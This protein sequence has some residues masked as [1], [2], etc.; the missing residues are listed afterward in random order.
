[1]LSLTM[2]SLCF[3]FLAASPQNVGVS[4]V[5]VEI[6]GYT[7][8]VKNDEIGVQNANLRSDGLFLRSGIEKHA[9][10]RWEEA[11]EIESWAFSFVFNNPHLRSNEQAGIYLR[12]TKEPSLIGPF[13]GGGATYDGIM[14][15]IGFQGMSPRIAYAAN[16]GSDY[17]ILPEYHKYAINYDEIN[18]KRFKDVEEFTFKVIKTK[19]H[20][21][22]EIYDGERLLYDN[23][24][25]YTLGG[26]KGFIGKGGYFAILTD[27]SDAP[28]SKAFEIKRAQLYK[29]TESAE[30]V[31]TD[32]HSATVVRTSR[33]P[34][35]IQHYNSDIATL[36]YRA[37]LAMHTVKDL[38]GDLPDTKLAQ[39][40]TE[41]DKAL[42][43]LEEK[44]TILETLSKSKSRNT[45]TLASLNNF[46]IKIK[47][48]Q[49]S[50]NDFQYVIEKNYKKDSPPN[51]ILQSIIFAAGCLTIYILVHREIT[52]IRAIQKN[53]K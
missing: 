38:I 49:R 35:S 53:N 51:T 30:Y 9:L 34:D 18:P 47:T 39:L 21:K 22:V 42:A 45:P 20:L 19:R 13:S 12:Y 15:G 40:Y 52:N 33:E 29:R 7:A 6:I 28:S 37:D 2:I 25:I 11:A 14:L 8:G 26:I 27:Y 24:R 4:E 36:I 48:I 17:G 5:P 43:T 16:N 10:M 3:N 44:V 46:D 1:M 31:S 41:L 32:L 50:L 23:F